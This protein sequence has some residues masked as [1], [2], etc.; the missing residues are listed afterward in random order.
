QRSQARGDLLAIGSTERSGVFAH[1]DQEVQ[2]G[3]VVEAVRH[4]R[5]TG[6]DTAQAWIRSKHGQRTRKESPMP[7]GHRRP[8]RFGKQGLRHQLLRAVSSGCKDATVMMASPSRSATN[9]SLF[10]MK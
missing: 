7:I 9:G 4:Q 8:V 5:S 2:V 6:S 10:E 1:H 3:V